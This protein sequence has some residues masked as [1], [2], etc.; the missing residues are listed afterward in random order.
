MKKKM[1]KVFR[2]IAAF[3]EKHIPIDKEY[4]EGVLFDT[5]QQKYFVEHNGQNL[6]HTRPVQVKANIYRRLKRAYVKY[7]I[8]GVLSYIY[9]I[10]LKFFSFEEVHHIE[11]GTLEVRKVIRTDIAEFFDKLIPAV[12]EFILTEK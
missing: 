1:T 8:E 7:G 12:N 6:V 5:V 10:K 11:E 9:T 2:D 3:I 4:A